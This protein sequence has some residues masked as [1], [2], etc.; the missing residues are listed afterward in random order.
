MM[1]DPAPPPHGLERFRSYLLLLAGMQLEARPRSKIEASD[2]VQE[3]LLEAHAQLDQFEG[4]DSALAAW[5]RQAL[6]N[7]LRDAWRALRREKRDIR[8]EQALAERVAD[9]SA[10]LEGMLAAVRPWLGNEPE[11]RTNATDEKY[12]AFATGRT[13]TEKIIPNCA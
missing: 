10:R 7:N 11:G 12:L 9:S 5:L 4:D 8:R 1:N 6:T 2:V 3:T 13:A